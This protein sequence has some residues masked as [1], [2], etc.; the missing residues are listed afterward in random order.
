MIF[1]LVGLPGS[2][3]STVGRHLARRMQL[4]FTDSDQVIVAA[5]ERTS[6]EALP[7][8]SYV[9]GGLE[10]RRIREHV[11]RLLEGGARA[12][13]KREERYRGLLGS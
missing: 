11:C 1:S 10:D 4:P 6:P 9:A 13:K 12:F 7:R 2:G 5:A 8:L 3:K